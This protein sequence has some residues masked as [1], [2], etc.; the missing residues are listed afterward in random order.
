[1][2]EKKRGSSISIPISNCFFFL[3]LTR[4]Y[5]SHSRSGDGEPPRFRLRCHRLNSTYLLAGQVAIVLDTSLHTQCPRTSAMRP[6]FFSTPRQTM[7][8]GRCLVSNYRPYPGPGW[9]ASW[10]DDMACRVGQTESNRI[11]VRAHLYSYKR[12]LAN[13]AQVPQ[14][15]IVASRRAAP[16]T[17][18]HAYLEYYAMFRI[19]D[20]LASPRHAFKFPRPLGSP[21]HALGNQPVYAGFAAFRAGSAYLLGARA[22]LFGPARAKTPRV[23]VFFSISA[24]MSIRTPVQL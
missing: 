7:L 20:R 9:Y 21:P 13:R 10:L 12:R 1:M 3:I 23:Y 15:G 18:L 14:L 2:T 24:S 11:R 4:A 6:I 22:W 5:H 16:R 17:R 19:P 8:S